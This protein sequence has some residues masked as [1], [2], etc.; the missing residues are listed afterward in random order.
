MGQVSKVHILASLC[1]WSVLG[2]GERA[3]HDNTNLE[4][5]GSAG[6]GGDGSAQDGAGRG[7]M[8]P[9]DFATAPDLAVPDGSAASDATEPPDGGGPLTVALAVGPEGGELTV[10][11]SRLVVPEGAVEEPVTITMTILD[12]L[13]APV[14]EGML[15]ATPA[16]RFEPS[17]LQFRV[18]VYLAIRPTAYADAAPGLIVREE[19][20]DAEW[21]AEPVVWWGSDDRIWGQLRHFSVGAGVLI[22]TPAEVAGAIADAMGNPD[23]DGDGIQNLVDNCPMTANADQADTDRD[24]RGDACDLCPAGT[25]DGL[26]RALQ[27]LVASQR[28]VIPLGG[29]LTDTDDSDG[30]GVGDACDNCPFVANPDQTDSNG[31]FFGDACVDD[32]LNLD[33]DGDGVGNLSDNCIFGNNADQADRDHDG[34]G[35]DCDNCRDVFNPL[36]GDWDVDGVG[37][38][39]DNCPLNE[40]EHQEDGDGDHVGDVC[41]LLNNFD[42]DGDGHFPNDN[43]PVVANSDQAD[44]DGD[45]IGDA[46]DNCPSDANPLQFDADW[47]GVGDTCDRCVLV[48]DSGNSDRDGDGV[49]DA[50]DACPEFAHPAY[51]DRPMY[52]R[53]SVARGLYD[54]DGDGVGWGPHDYGRFNWCDRC[55]RSRNPSSTNADGDHDGYGDLCDNCPGTI[56]DAPPRPACLNGPAVP[57]CRVDADC[58]GAAKCGSGSRCLEGADSIVCLTGEDCPGQSSCVGGRC[59]H[60]VGSVSCDAD[61]DCLGFSRCDNHE[62][63]GFSCEEWTRLPDAD[64]DDVGDF[65]DNCPDAPNPTQADL[66]G[67]GV[68]D[69]CDECLALPTPL[70]DCPCANRNC[71][72]CL[73]TD[74]DGVPACLDECPDDPLKVAPGVCGCDAADDV[75]GDGQ[76]DDAD[77][78]GF[79]DCNDA[80]PNDPDMIAP[81]VCGC[82]NGNASDADRDGVLSCRN[83]VIDNCPNVSNPDQAD[84]DGDGVGDACDFCDGRPAQP[85]VLN[86]VDDDC[87]GLVDELGPVTATSGGAVTAYEEYVRLTWDPLP[88]ARYHVYRDGRLVGEVAQDD[89][90]QP[91]WYTMYV[92]DQAIGAFS[93]PAFNDT[94]A[95]PGTPPTVS[96]AFLLPTLGTDT[97]KITVHFSAYDAPFAFRPGAP[98]PNHRYSVAAFDGAHADG[99]PSTAAGNRAPLLALAREDFEIFDGPNRVGEIPDLPFGVEPVDLDAPPGSI[100]GGV[101]TASDG[102]PGGVDLNLAGA[103]T[104]QG[105]D[106]GYRMRTFAYDALGQRVHESVWTATIYG[107]RGVG[108][109]TVLWE[110]SAADADADYAALP[111]ALAAQTTDHGAPVDG[112]GRY[113]RAQ[114]SAPGAATVFSTSDRGFRGAGGGGGNCDAIYHCVYACGTSAAGACIQG[115]IDRVG[116][117]EAD[118]ATPLV[119]CLMASCAPGAGGGFAP[120]P[121]FD[122]CAQTSCGAPY[123]A[124]APQALLMVPC[125]DDF[126]CP[127]GG[128]CL[129]GA[130]VAPP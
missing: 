94:G 126:W 65:C 7:D 118:K 29:R 108:P 50:C 24:R 8:L 92:N 16:I 55:P 63:V 66:D 109:L 47:D 107:Y 121:F 127:N 72:T 102:T 42:V 106:R 89:Q 59:Q 122:S 84:T 91:G 39:C 103:A 97:E 123:G 77:G 60:D 82:G 17:G 25:S 69:L 83:V 87:D 37:N 64:R 26:L 14:P 35:D 28:S 52:A 36:Q 34:M 40:N 32:P 88:G 9:N 12:A 124:C 119:A 44:A 111:D 85:E 99:A 130:C 4:P 76:V 6:S 112:S 98:G 116:G 1:L 30:D 5:D 33:L 113:Y 57:S 93:S 74:H 19:G 120:P 54:E 100:V 114:V 75:D 43:C 86:G 80:C 96:G 61:A 79:P 129:N 27:A 110:R 67:D 56:D 49:G 68:G 73:D 45:G 20:P 18:P 62:C 51:F 21:V 31:D 115:C 10:G 38:L 53:T 11:G 23:A 71:Q 117:T 90:V 104:V 3:G 15:S 46:C 125:Q 70:A 95:G 58:P 105:A 2:C 48:P 13:P 41:D 128:H 101:A 22:P 81:G 78:D